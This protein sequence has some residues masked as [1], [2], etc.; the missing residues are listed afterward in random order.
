MFS[1]SHFSPMNNPQTMS[2]RLMQGE[3]P[4]VEA[5]VVAKAKPMN[6]FSVGS[7][8]Q[9]PIALGSSSSY[10]TSTERPVARGLNENAAPIFQVCC[11]YDKETPWY[12]NYLTTS[13]I[14]SNN[15][16]HLE[17]A[18]SSVRQKMTRP[19]GDDMLDI[20]VNAM[21]WIIF[22]SATLKAAVHLGQDYQ[23]NLRATKNT[24]FEKVK[25]LFDISQ[26]D[27][28][29]KRIHICVEDTRPG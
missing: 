20:D 13:E 5:R 22:R 6:E 21:I 12:N 26:N 10:S 4:R 2:K 7:A 27:H 15:V 25:Q 16:G 11:G 17:K 19:Q 14:S 28:E 8:E 3:R 24:D 9:S 29:S 23:E 1:C 18:F